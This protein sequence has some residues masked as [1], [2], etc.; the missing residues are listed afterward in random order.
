MKQCTHLGRFAYPLE[1]GFGVLQST[2]LTRVLTPLKGHL[3]WNRVVAWHVP[4]PLEGHLTLYQTLLRYVPFPARGPSNML[5][6]T[7]FEGVA[8]SGLYLRPPIWIIYVC[9]ILPICTGYECMRASR[10]ANAKQPA[11]EAELRKKPLLREQRALA[12]RNK[13][14]NHM[15]ETFQYPELDCFSVNFTV[16]YLSSPFKWSPTA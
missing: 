13:R 16:N 7:H 11:I 15:V 3:T 8:H 14:N 6:C 2:L 5:L 1:G 9:A 12:A 4:A 10:D